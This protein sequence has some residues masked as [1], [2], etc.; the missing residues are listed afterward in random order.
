MQS[1]YPQTST[2]SRRNVLHIG[3]AATVGGVALAPAGSEASA[4]NDPAKTQQTV[5]SAPTNTITAKD[6]TYIL[7]KDWGT[8]QPTRL[9]SRLAAVSR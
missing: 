6:G 1:F 8:G 3:S 4:A 2:P 9:P 5:P 7:Y